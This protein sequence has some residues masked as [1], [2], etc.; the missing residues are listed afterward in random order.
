MG[1]RGS[2]TVP[3]GSLHDTIRT[4]EVTDLEPDVVDEKIYAP[5]LGIVS[6]R[7]LTGPTETALLVSVTG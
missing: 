6:E 4:L 5:G 7:S 3:Y 1:T 2:T